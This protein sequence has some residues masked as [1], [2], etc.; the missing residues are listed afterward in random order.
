MPFAVS[1]SR[2]YYS[3]TNLTSNVSNKYKSFSLPYSFFKSDNKLIEN[4]ENNNV[5]T[6][7][8]TTTISS[9]AIADS[10]Q[11]SERITRESISQQRNQSLSPTDLQSTYLQR[12]LN[13]S[14]NCFIVF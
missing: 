3:R 7:S 6:T 12:I 4:I 5:S 13:L 9:S 2:V 8:T 11:L 14:R 10:D 1:F